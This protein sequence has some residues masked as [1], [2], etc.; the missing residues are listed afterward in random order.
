MSTVENLTQGVEAALFPA[1]S[2]AGH[3]L[4]CIHIFRLCSLKESTKLVFL[5]MSERTRET[6][7]ETSMRAWSLSA[8]EALCVTAK[9]LFSPSSTSV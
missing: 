3:Q 7:A 6:W 4:I 1:K 5:N 8:A 9:R 2:Q